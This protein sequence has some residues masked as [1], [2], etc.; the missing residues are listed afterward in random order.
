LTSPTHRQLGIDA[1]VGKAACPSEG[2]YRARS[3]LSGESSPDFLN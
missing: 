2:K 1:V 3:T